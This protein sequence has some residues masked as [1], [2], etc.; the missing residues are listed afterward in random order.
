MYTAGI[1]EQEIMDRTGHRSDTAVRKYKQSYDQ[2]RKMVS[3]VLDPNKED[4]DLHG[5][6]VLKYEKNENSFKTTSEKS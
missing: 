6:K 2:V 4:T 5:S 3:N 1:D